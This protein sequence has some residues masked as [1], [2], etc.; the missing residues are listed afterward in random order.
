MITVRRL[1]IVDRSSADMARHPHGFKSCPVF[2]SEVA[3]LTAWVSRH[4]STP[5]SLSKYPL[6]KF[7]EGTV[8]RRMFS[9][10][11]SVFTLIVK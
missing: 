8:E 11:I 7:R 2:S 5:L 4:V 3:V 10:S 1:V 9:T 6:G